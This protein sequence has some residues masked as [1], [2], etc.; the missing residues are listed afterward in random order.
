MLITPSLIALYAL[1]GLFAIFLWARVFSFPRGKRR[2]AV[3]IAATFVVLMG[4]IVA[5]FSVMVPWLISLIL[6][7]PFTGSI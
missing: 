6:R 1:A 7:Q 2:Q 4:V 5:V 3:Q